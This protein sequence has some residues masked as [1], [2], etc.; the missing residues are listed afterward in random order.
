MDR[1]YRETKGAL[2]YPGL[3]TAGS[4]SLGLKR[5]GEGTV[6]GT[7]RERELCR[8]SCLSHRSGGLRMQPASGN[9]LPLRRLED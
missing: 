4:Q 5:Q 1:V 7:W 8:G 6:T 9:T 3:E 2:Q